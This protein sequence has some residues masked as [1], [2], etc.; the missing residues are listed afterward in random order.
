MKKP[1]EI[2]T[3]NESEI[4]ALINRI[5]SNQLS[6]GDKQLVARLLRLVLKLLRMVEGKNASIS[7]LK[8][9][10]FGPRTK[11][12]TAEKATSNDK[13]PSNDGGQ[14]DE[15]EHKSTPTNMS[16]PLENNCD[17]ERK[18]GHGRIAACEFTGAQQIYCQHETLKPGD[19]CPNEFCQGHLSD[20]NA[21]QI[22][23][24]REARPIIDALKFVRQV[25]RCHR[26]GER[27]AAQL[28][29]GVT[30]DKHDVS[31]DV[32]IAIM[33]YRAA[34]PFHRL[35][36]IQLM[37]G[38]PLPASTQFERAEVVANCGHP[39]YLE[40]IRQAAAS[41]LLHTD[42]TSVR[43]LSLIK[44]NQQLSEADRHGMH[45]TGIAARTADFDIALFFSG[46][47][48]SGENLSA[49]LNHRP[50]NLTEPI[51]MADAEH[52]NWVTDYQAIVAK[53]LV[54]G[55][56]QFVDCQASFPAEC[57]TVLDALADVYKIDAQTKDMTPPERLA[58]HQAHSKPIMDKLLAWMTAQIAEHQTEANSA[59]GQAFKY[60]KKH[61]PQ[62][63]AFLSV[64]GCPLDNNFVE[65]MLRKAVI[66][67]KN[68]LFFRNEHGAA[69]G[70][71]LQSIIETAVLNNVNPFDYLV[72]LVNNKQQ[73]RRHPQLWLPWNYQKAAQAA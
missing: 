26:C 34:M 38:V 60:M 45:T 57:K 18:P 21:P 12:R 58:F 56:R 43:I 49:L 10:L 3:T 36:Q 48:Y 5:E 51:L 68:A 11:K 52:K 50:D 61:W 54:H 53:C 30:A 19:K 62:L 29:E 37:T 44:E 71:V 16:A 65:R 22:F 46:R 31:A 42:D 55:R 4:E 39:I 35:E 41:D 40:L 14:G 72:T 69:V 27:F 32:M 7:Q 15:I 2:P 47:K 9:L 73:V 1:D 6:E 25:L 28:P 33:H 17:S 64:A 63:T 67:R 24:K 66:L 23:I 59:L 20:T 13:E 70:D 8:K